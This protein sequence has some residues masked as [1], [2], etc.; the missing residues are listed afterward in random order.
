MLSILAQW[1]SCGAVG[2]NQRRILTLQGCH[3][4]TEF[5]TKESPLNEFRKNNPYTL[6]FFSVSI[7]T[8]ME[9]HVTTVTPPG[10]AW[11][12]NHPCNVLIT[13]VFVC[14]V[15]A[16]P[17]CCSTVSTSTSFWDVFICVTLVLHPSTDSWP[18]PM[19]PS[20]ITFTEV[21]GVVRGLSSNYNVWMKCR[22]GMKLHRKEEEGTNLWSIK[23]H[24]QPGSLSLWLD[25]SQ[26]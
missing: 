22:F 2:W 23:S 19:S 9:S 20:T 11:C 10:S 15:A 3:L 1:W 7:A 18:S 13:S 6:I 8:Y 25:S 26:S 5:P 16:S 17:F 12:S 4:K 24:K 14:V 21:L